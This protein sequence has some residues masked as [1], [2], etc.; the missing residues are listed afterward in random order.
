[1][2]S[3]QKFTRIWIY[4]TPKKRW[5]FKCSCDRDMYEVHKDWWDYNLAEGEKEIYKGWPRKDGPTAKLQTMQYINQNA[6]IDAGPN[7]FGVAHCPLCTLW[8]LFTLEFTEQVSCRSAGFEFE[9]G[10]TSVCMVEGRISN[11]TLPILRFSSSEG[12][13]RTRKWMWEGSFSMIGP[14]R[15]FNNSSRTSDEQQFRSSS[16]IS[17]G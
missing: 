6:W 13:L 3:A 10:D 5:W 16:T 11:P 9:K 17:K 1:M 2:F 8:P 14:L 12:R 15:R 7:K 4:S